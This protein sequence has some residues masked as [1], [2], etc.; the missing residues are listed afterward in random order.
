MRVHLGPHAHRSLRHNSWM[1]EVYLSD[2]QPWGL[3]EGWGLGPNA[4]SFQLELGGCIGEI[5]L[6]ERK[7]SA[8]ACV[9]AGGWSRGRRGRGRGFWRRGGGGEHWGCFRKAAAGSRSLDRADG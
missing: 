6:V 5:G 7:L 9:L 4:G 1:S 3:S 2:S 8:H